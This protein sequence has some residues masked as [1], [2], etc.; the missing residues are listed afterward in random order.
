M[1]L[2]SLNVGFYAF[3]VI[4][5]TLL[6]FLS[7]TVEAIFPS[8]ISVFAT[9]RLHMDIDLKNDIIT[10][11]WGCFLPLGD[12]CP[13]SSHTKWHHSFL[14]K[15][16]PFTKM[17]FFCRCCSPLQM[18][19]V[20]LGLILCS[21]SLMT[22]TSHKEV[23]VLWVSVGLLGFSGASLLPTTFTWLQRYMFLNSK[24]VGGYFL[25]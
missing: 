23:E 25:A 9:A 1:S 14:H 8:L 18:I 5:T 22:W 21:G 17:I 19:V 2:K 20:D 4:T 11:F 10:Y 12:S 13:L 3:A 6:V 24:V 16:H 15:E 7:C